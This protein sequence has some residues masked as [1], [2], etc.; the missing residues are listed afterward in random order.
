M[1]KTHWLWI[2]IIIIIIIGLGMAGVIVFRT[3]PLH[4]VSQY[5]L[6]V[7]AEEAG[8]MLYQVIH[9]QEEQGRE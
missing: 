3:T 2:G 1:Q 7:L 9:R 5:P 8:T 4:V 6:D